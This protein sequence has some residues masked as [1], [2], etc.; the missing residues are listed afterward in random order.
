MMAGFTSSIH[1]VATGMAVRNEMLKALNETGQA[2]AEHA[3]SICAVDTGF[4]RDHIHYEADLPNGGTLSSD[5]DYSG[6]VNYGT[7]HMA[8]QPFWEPTLLQFDQIAEQKAMAH[9]AKVS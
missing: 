6:F 7:V 5:A 9:G 1:I 8:A 2:L 4:M 3:Q